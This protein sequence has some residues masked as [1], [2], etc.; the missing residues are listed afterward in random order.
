MFG[1][2]S[3][4]KL[5]LAIVGCHWNTRG[6]TLLPVFSSQV[7]VAMLYRNLPGMTAVEPTAHLIGS[8]V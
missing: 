1:S 2:V 7:F 8:G 4:G 3:R 5:A 6:F